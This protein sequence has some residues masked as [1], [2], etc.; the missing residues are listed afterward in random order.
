MEKAQVVIEELMTSA[1]AAGRDA[2]LRA[3]AGD[4]VASG[5]VLAYYDVLDVL[6]EQAGQIGLVFADKTLAAFDPDELLRKPLKKA[7]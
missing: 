3:A 1:I 2:A 7:A 6:K 5:Q 4:V